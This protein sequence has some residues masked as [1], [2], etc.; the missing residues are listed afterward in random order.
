V[1]EFDGRR[2]SECSDF[3]TNPHFANSESDLRLFEDMAEGDPPD[4]PTGIYPELVVFKIE[5]VSLGLAVDDHCA[6]V[7]GPDYDG[8]VTLVLLDSSGSCIDVVY[9]GLAR[10]KLNR[11]R[12]AADILGA[13]R[14]FD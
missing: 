6:I 2:Y 5:N 14:I 4:I 11:H 7:R 9:L 13:R 8:H 12:G 3:L 1:G 10:E